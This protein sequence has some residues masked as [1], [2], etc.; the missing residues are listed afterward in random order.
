MPIM[1]IH[2]II[3]TIISVQV[4]NALE[5]YMGALQ[6]VS[7]VF[8]FTPE[9]ESKPRKPLPAKIPPKRRPQPV[10]EMPRARVLRAARLPTKNSIAD[11]KKFELGNMVEYQQGRGRIRAKVVGIEH[12]TGLLTL[13]KVDDLRQLIRPASKV[14]PPANSLQPKSS[15]TPLAPVAAVKPIVRKRSDAEISDIRVSEPEPQPSDANLPK[16]PF[17]EMV[18]KKMQEQQS[19]EKS[20]IEI[21]VYKKDGCQ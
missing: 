20:P 8:G 13:E 11:V 21:V 3:Q 17:W 16:D 1:D 18:S 14:I 5:P 10:L 15:P 19:Q 9:S 6:Q 12:A 2:S 4:Q 7:A